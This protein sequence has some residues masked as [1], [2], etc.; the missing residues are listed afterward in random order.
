MAEV[1]PKARE[2][3]ESVF[4][5]ALVTRFGDPGA[6]THRVRN[7][8]PNG[9]CIDQAAMLRQRQTVLIDVGVLEEVG[10]TIMWVTGDMAG[11][12]FAH[13]IAIDAA[14]TRSKPAHVE[15]GWNADP[16]SIRQR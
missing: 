3:R 12:K 2:R 5:K 7:L 8:S 10:A 9:A 4:L 15:T 11:L 6:T 1:E 14:K 13:P 16:W